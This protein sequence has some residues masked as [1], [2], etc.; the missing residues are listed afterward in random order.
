MKTDDGLNHSMKRISYEFIIGLVFILAGCT[1]QP[2]I[3]VNPTDDQRDEFPT[4]TAASVSAQAVATATAGPTAIPA[5]TSLNPEGPYVLFE[6]EDGIWIAN[7]DGTFLTRLSDRGFVT[8]Y[9][10]PHRAISPGGDRLA[11]IILTEAGAKLIIIHLP[12]GETE[13]VAHLSDRP[14]SSNITSQ[15][16]LAYHAITNYDNVAWQPGEGR[17]LAFIG[18]MDGPTADL[19]VYDT[20]TKEIAQ[21][22]DGLSQALFP[23]WSPDGEYILN[24]GGSWLPPFGGALVGYSRADGAWAVRVSDGSVIRQPGELKSHFNFLAWVDDDHYLYSGSAEGCNSRDIRLVAVDEVTETTIFEGCYDYYDALSPEDGA[25]LLSS[26]GCEQCPLGEGTFLLLPGETTSTQVWPEKAWGIDWIPESDVFHAY[27]L[28]LVSS[29]GQRRYDIPDTD[30]SFN[31]ALSS[32]GWVAWEVIENRQGRVELAAP[33]AE[34]H[35]ILETNVATMIWDP[36]DG[37]TLL[38]VSG[39]GTLY[40]LTAPDFVTRIVGEL[41]DGADQAI[42]LP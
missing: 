2:T 28:G 29:D 8:P 32:Q 11:Q 23:S 17:L 10:D 37:N 18:A 20:V 24:F 27:P 13:F 31:P 4:G 9:Q 7:P 6:G 19:Y 38:V 33:D 5:P 35:T 26:L 42:W 40:A 12:G 16:G 22:T 1:A 15:V 25:L 14:E 3:V 36:E 30:A 21:L 41:G 34:F 39:G